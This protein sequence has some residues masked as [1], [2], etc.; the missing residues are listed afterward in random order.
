MDLLEDWVARA[1]YALYNNYQEL[2]EVREQ[3]ADER[4]QNPAVPDQLRDPADEVDNNMADHNENP[5]P[6]DE[7]PVYMLQAVMASALP[8]SRLI[9]ELR[10]FNAYDHVDPVRLTANVNLTLAT[11]ILRYAAL[12]TMV[13]L[14]DRREL[15]TAQNI[16]VGQVIEV[17]GYALPAENRIANPTG[18]L[19]ARFHALPADIKAGFLNEGAA[20][21]AYPAIPAERPAW[22]LS[23]LPLVRDNFVLS[24]AH[25][26]TIGV[27][28][29][30]KRGTTSDEFNTRISEAMR[31]ELGVRVMFDYGAAR[32]FYRNVSQYI[33]A[34]NMPRV[35]DTMIAILPGHALRLRLVMQ[36][37][38]NSGLTIFITIGRA[39][40]LYNDFRWDR[41]DYISHGDMGRFEQAVEAVAG[42]PY[43]GFGQDLGPA[44][45]TN[46][47]TFGYVAVELLV[48]LNGER[49]LRN[50]QGYRTGVRNQQALNDIITAYVNHRPGIPAENPMEEAFA[51]RLQAFMGVEERMRLF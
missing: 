10:V 25:A 3:E 22:V 26:I 38:A 27:V 40:R 33:N 29:Y 15:L 28:G 14:G 44:R 48:L 9:T 46:F 49:H 1:L 4:H 36:Q 37:A 21:P 39:L 13:K 41:V 2:A 51:G 45:S 16:R 35:V 43:Y 31:D 20:I 42:N 32:A 50:R 17:F 19:A 11:E 30:G 6:V 7:R 47:R 5:I 8:P 12:S 34:V 18:N 23:L 24:P